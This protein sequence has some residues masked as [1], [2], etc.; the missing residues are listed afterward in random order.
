M[1]IVVQA[2]AVVWNWRW[3]LNKGLGAWRP[4]VHGYIHILAPVIQGRSS[5]G[6]G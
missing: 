4:K 5:G 3:L 1:H 6:A 2:T